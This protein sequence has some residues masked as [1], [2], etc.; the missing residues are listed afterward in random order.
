MSK[1]DQMHRICPHCGYL[2]DS[3]IVTKGSFWIELVL[4]IFF[5]IPGVIYSLWRLTSRA[6]VCPSCGAAGMIPIDS[7]RGNLLVYQFHQKFVN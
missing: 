6:S 4:W 7:P 1:D 3:K 2:G 5:I